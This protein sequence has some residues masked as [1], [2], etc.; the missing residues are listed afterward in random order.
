MSSAR[1][2]HL[3]AFM[4]PVSIRT[5]ARRCPGAYPDANF[6]FAQLK[7]FAQRLERAKFDAFFHG[8]PSASL[9]PPRPPS[10][11]PITPRAASPRSIT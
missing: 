11:R 1:Q 10:M 7:R 9:P 4:R 5:G 3:G 6:N 8:R 2:L